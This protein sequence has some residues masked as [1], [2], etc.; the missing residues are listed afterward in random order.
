[1]L[2]VS[3]DGGCPGV[4][5]VEAGVIGATSQ[6]YPAADG[7]DGRRGDRRVRQ[8]RQEAGSR[9][10]ASTSSTPAST[11]ITDKP[12]EGVDLD[13]RRGRP[14]DVLGLIPARSLR[15]RLTDSGRAIGRG[16]PL[17]EL[18]AAPP[19]SSSRGCARRAREP[20]TSRR[21]QPMFERR[22]PGRIFEERRAGRSGGSSTSCTAIRRRSR[23]SSCC[24]ASS[25][26][27]SLVGGTLLPPVQPVAD[28]AAG[29]DHRHR[30]RSRRR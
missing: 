1:M 26:S 29:H 19:M 24:S 14:G 7:V 10:Q 17:A 16:R 20:R 18:S 28:P 25:S 2:I 30:R 6:Q 27:A 13:H 21:E 12:V 4:K 22:R 5:N 3:V 23:S 11:L 9:P 8:D 15:S